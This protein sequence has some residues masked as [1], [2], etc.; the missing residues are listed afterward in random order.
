MARGGGLKEAPSIGPTAVTPSCTHP[1]AQPPSPALTAA[2][3]AA[4]PHSNLTTGPGSS[5]QGFPRAPPALPALQRPATPHAPPPPQQKE[6]GASKHTHTPP[7]GMEQSQHPTTLQEPAPATSTSPASRG[8]APPRGRMVA[9]APT[10]PGGT[11][12]PQ[13][14]VRRGTSTRTH[15]APVAAPQWTGPAD[16]PGAAQWPE[17]SPG[18]SLPLLGFLLFP[19]PPSAAFPS[20]ASLLAAPGPA[21]SDQEVP[22]CD[23]AAMETLPAP[24]PPTGLTRHSRHLG[25]GTR[26]LP[27]PG[28]CCGEEVGT[29]QN[30]PGNLR[31]FL[32]VLHELPRLPV[33]TPILLRPVLGSLV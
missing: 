26:R 12:P 18:L 25:L 3:H 4:T 5:P 19:G 13:W 21:A 29:T 9:P 31:N 15:A 14:R 30:R 7:L 33:W 22:R 11:R 16:H 32:A 28:S 17:Q 24:A 8:C 10:Q 2:P 23:T 6:Q 1:H 20:G 27:G